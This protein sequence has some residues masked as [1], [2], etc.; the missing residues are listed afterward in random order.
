MIT[1]EDR[2]SYRCSTL[3][4]PSRYPKVLA[5][6]GKAPPQYPDLEEEEWDED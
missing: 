2:Q 3:L 6:V 4:S 1:S 5:T